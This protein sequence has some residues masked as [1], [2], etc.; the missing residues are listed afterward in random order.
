MLDHLHGF[1]QTGRIINSDYD[2]PKQNHEP[3]VIHFHGRE[4]LCKCGARA[5]W[6]DLSGIWIEVEEG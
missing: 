5:V 3:Q 4:G 6:C 1:K 2:D